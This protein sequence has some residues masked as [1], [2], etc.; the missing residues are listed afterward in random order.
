V[1][2]FAGDV[3]D[4]PAG[5][6][7]APPTQPVGPDD[8]FPPATDSPGARW[9]R[10]PML[11]VLAAFAVFWTW[12][13]FFASKESVNRIGDR[14]WADRAE[15]ICTAAEA[16]RV[17][18]ADFTRVDPNDPESIDELHALA[19]NLDQA[20]DILEEML[21]DVVAVPPNDPKGIGIVPLWEADYR[22]YLED[23]RQFTDGLRDGNTGPFSE[24]AVDGIPISERIEAFASD[25][26][27]PACAPPYDMPT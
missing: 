5:D 26:E 8:G 24:T 15:Q 22:T 27:M 4:Q 19:D 9:W 11:V 16:E 7:S 10:I 2:G 12:A 1:T 25:N 6:E 3:S 14:E 18:L 23:R 13:L 21:N 20:T 17:G